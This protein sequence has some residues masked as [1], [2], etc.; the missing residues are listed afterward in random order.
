MELFIK[1][2]VS[3]KIR[4]DLYIVIECEPL[5]RLINYDEFEKILL[6]SILRAMLRNPEIILQCIGYIIMYLS[7]DLNKYAFDI[8]KNFAGKSFSIVFKFNKIFLLHI[9]N[10]NVNFI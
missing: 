4:P 1:V 9:F 5:L 3:C 2:A 8:G 10:I 6:P 7:I